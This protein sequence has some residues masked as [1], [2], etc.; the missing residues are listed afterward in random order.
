MI[1]DFYFQKGLFWWFCQRIS[2]VFLFAYIAPLLYFWYVYYPVG[3]VALWKGFLLH[4]A[5]KI[6][7]FFAALS[8]FV[9]ACIG[10]WVVSTDYVKII[11]VRNIIL[12]ILY[13]VVILSSLVMFFIFW[14]Y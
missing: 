14:R 9:H 1:Y 11:S 4:P 5:M 12:C 3:T 2:A 8:L 7:G 13:I 10:V 6:L